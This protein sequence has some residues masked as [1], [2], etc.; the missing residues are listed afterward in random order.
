VSDNAKQ[1]ITGNPFY[2]LELPLDCSR[3]EIEREGHKLLGMLEVGLSGADTYRTPLGQMQR[4]AELVRGAM[5]ELRDPEK[6]IGH[7]LWARGGLDT[8]FAVDEADP[9]ESTAQPPWGEAWRA[10]GFKR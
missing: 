10:S 8:V 5:A 7:E 2:V 3:M 4:T 6:R 1:R 9:V